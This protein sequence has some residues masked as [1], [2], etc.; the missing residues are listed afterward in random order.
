MIAKAPRM[1]LFELRNTDVRRH[2]L[3]T[4]LGGDRRRAIA[5]RHDD[6]VLDRRD[7][8]IAR[9]PLSLGLPY[10][11]STARLLDQHALSIFWAHQFEFA[12]QQRKSRLG[13]PS[14]HRRQHSQHDQWES[15]RSD[16]QHDVALKERRS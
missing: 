5:L 14:R 12:G 2:C 3:R 11:L 6:S 4:D 1:W 9:S 13:G 10:E 15:E 8:G 16:S 7:F